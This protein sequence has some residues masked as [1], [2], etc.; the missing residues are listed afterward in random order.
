MFFSCNCLDW[1]WNMQSM[2]IVKN[3]L[4][5]W[6]IGMF[7]YFECKYYSNYYKYLHLSYDIMTGITA[8][9]ASLHWL[10]PFEREKKGQIHFNIDNKSKSIDLKLISLANS[11]GEKFV[12]SLQ[13]K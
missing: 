4:V 3:Q 11:T 8:D 7:P 2:K 5:Y 13:F 12:L 1:N 9:N 10:L 6:S